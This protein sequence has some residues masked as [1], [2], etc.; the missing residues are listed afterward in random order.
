MQP[1]RSTSTPRLRGV[2]AAI[3]AALLLVGVTGTTAAAGVPLR[4]ATQHVQ[5]GAGDDDQGPASST[6]HQAVTPHAAKIG[7]AKRTGSHPGAPAA[8]PH[9]SVTV[10]TVGTPEATRPG[11][12]L[13]LTRSPGSSDGRAPP[14]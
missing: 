6:T 11:A 3:I 1:P 5:P 14:A 2:L 13:H 12:S 4:A 9:R 7:A 10:A 8:T